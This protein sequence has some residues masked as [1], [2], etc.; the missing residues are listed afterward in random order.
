LNASPDGWQCDATF[1]GTAAGHGYTAAGKGLE[2]RFA[3]TLPPGVQ[4][5]T[6]RM[7]SCVGADKV[8]PQFK[9]I[10][11]APER[12]YFAE[13][14]LALFTMQFRDNRGRENGGPEK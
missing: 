6:L 8:R 13:L 1:C 11:P 14:E 3:P 7:P 2:R 9:E 10:N 5:L 12:I 4:Q